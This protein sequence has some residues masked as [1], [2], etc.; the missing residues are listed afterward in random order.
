MLWFDVLDG[1]LGTP[2]FLFITA[3]IFIATGLIYF[4]QWVH[5][6]VVLMG[7][8]AFGVICVYHFCEEDTPLWAYAIPIIVCVIGYYAIEN[9]WL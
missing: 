4:T 5:S 6:L 1:R 2:L 8:I 7:A 3:S 9:G